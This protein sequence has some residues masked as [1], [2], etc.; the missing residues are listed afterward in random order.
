MHS[1]YGML[2]LNCACLSLFSVCS[3]QKCG[4]T[5]KSSLFRTEFKLFIT[6]LFN[7][8]YAWCYVVPNVCV[9]SFG[10]YYDVLLLYCH[11]VPFVHMQWNIPN[12]ADITFGQVVIPSLQ[13]L[14]LAYKSRCS[15]LLALLLVVILLVLE[16]IV[17]WKELCKQVGYC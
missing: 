6:Y 16:K 8:L 2:K 7:I 12:C 14:L 4:P 17:M 5:S 9:P 3:G 10:L 15:R 1:K 11:T 13:S